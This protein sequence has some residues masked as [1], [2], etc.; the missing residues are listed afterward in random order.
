MCWWFSWIRCLVILQVVLWLLMNMQVLLVGFLVVVMMCISLMLCVVSVWIRLWCLDI[1]VVSISLVRCECCIQ[2]VSLLVSNGE[3][4]LQG[5]IC[6][7]KLVLWYVVSMLFCML[8][9][10]YG[11]GLLQISLIMKV[12]LLCRLCVDGLG[13]QLS[14]VMVCSIWVW[15]VC[16]IEGLLLIICEIVFSEILVFFVMFLMVVLCMGFFWGWLLFIIVDQVL[17]CGSLV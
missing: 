17:F 9:M 2:L 13:L 4:E 10:W 1:G 15:V 3:F 11:F 8:M 12:V 16:I 6:R 5:W 14:L 7:L